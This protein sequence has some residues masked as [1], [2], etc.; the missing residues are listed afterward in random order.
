M[1]QRLVPLAGLLALLAACN[2]GPTETTG[3]ASAEEAAAADTSRYDPN[4]STDSARMGKTTGVMVG[5]VSLTPDKTLAQ[6]TAA[7]PELSQLL[8]AAQLAG[9]A[10]NLGNEGPY[11]V[12]APSNAA[13]RN[14]PYGAMA[15]LKKPESK[16]NLKG[17]VNYHIIQSRLLAMDLRD[18]Q[19][20]TTLNGQKIKIGVKNGKITV[21]NATVS[22]PDVVSSNGVLHVIDKV[23][24]PPK[25]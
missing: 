2:S 12:F 6:N 15:G 13:F 1:Y 20:L 17:L 3:P 18:G 23:L 5:K 19:E 8:E 11:T 16:E 9:L 22:T 7:T 4:A 14:L 10:S 24:L 25:E 21:N